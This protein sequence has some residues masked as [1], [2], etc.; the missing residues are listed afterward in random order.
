MAAMGEVHG[1]HF[2]AGFEEGKI[3]GHVRAAAGVGLD[4]GVFRAE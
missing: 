2:V 3:N 4:I 1:Q